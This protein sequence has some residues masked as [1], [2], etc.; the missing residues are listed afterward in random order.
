MNTTEEEVRRKTTSIIYYENHFSVSNT[1][2]I[3]SSVF[4]NVNDPFISFLV[5]VIIHL[6]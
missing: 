2:S 1:L 3:R 4:Y 5:Y 6:I